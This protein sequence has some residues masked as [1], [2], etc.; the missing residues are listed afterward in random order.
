MDP[1]Q[2]QRRNWEGILTRFNLAKQN[3]PMLVLKLAARTTPAFDSTHPSHTPVPP[4]PLEGGAR[5]NRCRKWCRPCFASIWYYIGERGLPQSCTAPQTHGSREPAARSWAATET[6][7][8]IA[9]AHMCARSLCAFAS[10]GARLDACVHLAQAPEMQH[11]GDWL[12]VWLVQPVSPH[13]KAATEPGSQETRLRSVSPEPGSQH[14]GY[15]QVNDDISKW[16]AYFMI[17]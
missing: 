4:K 17:Y 2:S 9:T 1:E 3:P 10:P 14:A 7:F 5:T 6:S 8:P 12:P 16:L 13:A 15:Y 11:H